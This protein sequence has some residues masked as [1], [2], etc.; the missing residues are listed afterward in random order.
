[1]T[2]SGDLEYTSR[3]TDDL[4]VMGTEDM[5]A[6]EKIIA[7]IKAQDAATRKALIGTHSEG[8]HCDEVVATMMLLYTEQFKNSMIVRTRN[9][10]IFP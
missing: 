1:M 5:E 8:F 2:V 3:I 7:E 10:A 6:F 4:V 9:E